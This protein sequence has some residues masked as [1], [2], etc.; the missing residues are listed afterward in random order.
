LKIILCLKLQ[1]TVLV[2]M[3]NF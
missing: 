3:L 2:S 1:V